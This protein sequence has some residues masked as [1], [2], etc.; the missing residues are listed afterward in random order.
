MTEPMGVRFPQFYLTVPGPCPYLPERLERKVFTQLQGGLAAPLN[1]ALTH[2]GFRRSQNIAYKPACDSC[3]A[4]ISVRIVAEEFEA[5]R[6]QKRILRRNQDIESESHVPQATAEQYSL[7][8]AYLDQRHTGGGMS[9]MTVLDYSAMVEET[10]VNTAVIEYRLKDAAFNES[11]LVAVALTDT[12]ADGLSMVYSY[13]E[14]DLSGR[15][16]GSYLIMDHVR[17]AVELDLPYV[18]LGYW[19][20]G[21]SKMD[22]KAK[23]RPLEALTGDGWRPFNETH[24]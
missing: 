9:D 15:S 5:S 6:S 1:D 24:A 4:C 16:L 23:F 2:A 19:V 3:N 21:C 8:R 22:Y 14:P 7:L 20:A 17:R 11:N 13:F 12:L 10:S 18:Y